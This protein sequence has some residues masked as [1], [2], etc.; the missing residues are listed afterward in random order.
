MQEKV[1]PVF[2]VATANDISSLPPEFLRKG[3]FDEMFFVDLPDELERKQIW[4]IVIKR[5]GRKAADFDSVALSR[6]A[7]QFTGAEIDAVF[8]DSL[9]DSYLES[10]EPSDLDLATAIT[11]TVPLAKLM[12]GQI[13]ALRHWAKGRAREAAG[14]RTTQIKNSRRVTTG[15]TNWDF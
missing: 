10:R 2:I 14:N 7:E 12:D 8:V 1:T 3:R 15:G 4:D 9:F 6:A 5:H 11:R 13:T